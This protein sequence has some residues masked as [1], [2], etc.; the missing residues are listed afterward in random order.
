MDNKKVL[1]IT[2]YWPPAGGP[3][4]Q[5]W[6]KFIKYLP[7]FNIEPIVFVPSNPSYPLRDE[8]LLD[9]V[10]K[11]ITIIKQ[12]IIEPYKWASVVSK[13]KS[14][15]ISKG[16]ITAAKGQ[17]LSERF[18][19]FIRGNFFIPDARKY[20]I[21][22]SS[23]YLSEYISN[24]SIDTVITTGPPHSVHLIGRNLKLKTKVNWF[25]DF[26]DPWTN[27]GYHRQLKLLY[28]ARRKHRYL[29]K[30][31]LNTADKII[32]TSDKTKIIF[33]QLTQ[34]PL[35]V[36]TNG[37]DIETI[38]NVILDDVFSMAH[39]GSLLSERNPQ[40]LWEVLSEIVIENPDFAS[41][42]QL[43]LIGATSEQV[44]RSLAFFNLTG[45]VHVMEYVTH[46]E[47]IRHQRQ[48]QILLLIEKDSED[49]SYIIP[50]KLFEY[51]ASNRPILAIGPEKS[52]VADILKNTHTGS[53]FLYHQKE[54]IKKTILGMF[55]DFQ[56]HKLRV[57]PKRIEQYS[58]KNI[59]SMLARLIK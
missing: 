21:K 5:R 19:L 35:E 53:Y 59:T 27:I 4:V 10:S 30:L 42:F 32:V 45:H 9:E 34:Q 57:D 44:L 23:K 12:P 2:Y 6:L 51:M 31:I 40:I 18:M 37:Y 50:G 16:I 36:I 15:T 22:P 48:S 56:N 20:W 28:F 49:T 52:D 54:L 1:I 41:L 26:R 38:D 29:E 33:Q 8:S 13:G 3:G 58:R 39:I 25:A 43:K 46:S 24:N 47:A 11:D 17:S 7:E 14:K 55:L